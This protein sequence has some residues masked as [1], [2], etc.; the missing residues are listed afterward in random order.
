MSR[1][2]RR[3]SVIEAVQW[4]PGQSHPGIRWPEVNGQIDK[5]RPFVTTAQ[6]QPAYLTEG[7]WIIAEAMPG[8]Y[9]PCVQT[10]FA[11]T[12]DPAEAL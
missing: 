6:G 9:Y 2:R 5:G 4:F 7:D 8:R 12:Y 11:A 10:V 1:F 3:V